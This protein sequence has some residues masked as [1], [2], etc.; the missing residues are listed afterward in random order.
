M[1]PIPLFGESVSAYS[2]VVSAQRRLNCFYVQRKDGDKNAAILRG[3]PGIEIYAVALGSP[4]RGFWVQGTTL[5]YVA[6]SGFYSYTDAGGSV[7]IGNISSSSGYVSMTDNVNQIGIVDGV[8]L[9]VYT[10]RAGSYAQSTL[11]D[12]GS[13]GRVA[14]ANFPNGAQTITFLNGYT[15]VEVP[16]SLFVYISAPNGA[17]DDMTNWTNVSSLPNY[18]IKNDSSDPML[19]V[20]AMNGMLVAF[21]TTSI[22]YFQ[23]VGTS[24]NPFARIVGSSQNWGLAALWSRQFIANTI[25]FLGQNDQGGVQVMMLDGYTPKRVSN[26][27]I[28]NIILSFE[29]SESQPQASSYSDATAISYMFEGHPMYQINFAAADRSLL[30][31][32]LTNTWDE[33]QTGVAASG[34][35]MA[36]IGVA[37]KNRT[38]ISDSSGANIY[39]FDEDTYDDNGTAI[40]RQV[41]SRHINNGGNLFGIAEVYLDMETGV[42]V[43]DGTQ[44]SDPQV[45]MEVSKDGGRTWGQGRLT[46]LGAIGGYMV[47]AV[48][49]RLGMARDFVFRFTVTDPVKFTVVRGSV[50][51]QTAE[52]KDG[53]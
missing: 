18:V 17:T 49:R 40:K 50:V 39:T 32:M 19:A 44:G 52:G 6:G 36:D 48:W 53:S 14:D 35:H 45:M 31:D 20:N 15:M 1:K 29:N 8:G 46:S 38:L 23:N 33:V 10:L 11:N 27:D 3:T 42:G 26:D 2:Q 24:P 30:Y 47:R 4:I 5:Y 43:G 22:E 37:Y 41:V 12:A 25:I 16:N 13:F 9:W 34:R 28:E 21:G 51:L 7:L